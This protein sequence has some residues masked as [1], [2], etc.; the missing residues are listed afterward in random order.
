MTKLTDEQKIGILTGVGNISEK[1]LKHLGIPSIKVGN[2]KDYCREL[3]PCET[4]L[5]HSW[6]TGLFESVAA[7]KTAKMIGDKVRFAIVPGAKIKLSPYC[8]EVTEDG[9]FSSLMSGTYMKAAVDAGINT[10]ASGYYVSQ[11]DVDWLDASPN[12]RILNE[13]LIQ[14]YEVASEISGSDIIVSDN[15]VQSGAYKEICSYLQIGRAH[16]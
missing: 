16:V 10:G 15:G 6:N 2:I 11:Y 9:Y 3:Y 8:N 12:K 4:S 7:Q 5:A 14:P 1:D 13:Y